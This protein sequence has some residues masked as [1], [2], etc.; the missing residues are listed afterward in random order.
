MTSPLDPEAWRRLERLV[1][2]CL[3]LP[4]N[5]RAGF[6]VDQCSDDPEQLRQAL[7]LV[8]AAAEADVIS[9]PSWQPALHA[10]E[11]T[12][13][14]TVPHVGTT[15]V[16]GTGVDG[17][18]VDGTGVDGTPPQPG[19]ESF[20]SIADFRVLSE[21]GRGGM[22]KVYLA[23]QLKPVRREVA[24]K[25]AGTPLGTEGH[26]RLAAER[27]AMARL[28]HP[29]IAQ[30][31]EAGS[32]DEGLPFFA[33]ER[34]HGLPITQY[35]DEHQLGIDAR[36]RLFLDVCSGVQHAHQKG[37]LH[38]DLK[39][40]NVM[41]TEI[42][43]RPTPKIIDF[44]IAKALD[45]PLLGKRQTLTGGRLLGTPA[46]M[47][48]EALFGDTMAVDTRSDVFSLG[49]LLYELLVGEWPVP[50][51]PGEN[52]LAY[53]SRL[54]ETATQGP[55]SRWRTLDMEIRR[56]RAENRGGD[57]RSLARRLQGDL[58][59]IVLES[60][61]RDPEQRYASVSEMAADIQRFLNNEP[62]LA[63]RPSTAYRLRKLVRRHRPAV[64]SA[65]L[66]LLALTG[67]FIARSLEAQRANREAQEAGAAR[68][69]TALMLQFLLDLFASANPMGQ[70][71]ADGRS[72]SAYDLLRLGTDRL[73]EG[74]LGESPRARTK[75]LL[76]TARV[77]WSL[78]NPREGLRLAEVALEICREQFGTEDPDF[79]TSLFL[80]GTL[81][82]ETDDYPR[83][84]QLLLQALE[85]RESIHGH[86]STE[87]ANVLVNLGAIHEETSRYVEA[88]PFYQRALEI[89]SWVHGTDSL[90]AADIHNNL[91]VLYRRLNQLEASENE[92]NRALEIRRL[93]LRPD[94]PDIALSLRNLADLLR[95]MDRYEEAEVVAREALANLRKN[96]EPNHPRIGHTLNSLGNILKAQ[97]KWQ[98]ADEAFLGVQ[99]IYRAS[100]G[101]DHAW[102]AYPYYNRGHL[103]AGQGRFQASIDAQRRALEIREAH[104]ENGLSIAESRLLLGHALR[105]MGEL[106]QAEPL[107][108]AAHDFLEDY[109]GAEYFYHH[110]LAE[111]GHLYLDFGRMEQ[112]QSMFEQ[113]VDLTRNQGSS[114]EN[115]GHALF[116][117]A[118]LA[119]ARGDSQE[120]RRLADEA[121]S[122]RS[123]LPGDH[124]WIREIH[125]LRAQTGT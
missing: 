49:V 68:D 99:D 12:P 78:G 95:E 114:Q 19:S 2:E 41:V 113:C 45:R 39:P 84:E 37:I 111:L 24:L 25:V 105:G 82:S 42:E 64:I 80:V 101:D 13:T 89:Q 7:D 28:S 81:A 120:A 10:A 93:Q 59:W 38:R 85:A 98:E 72:L 66:L 29:N 21:L 97:G 118:R 125:E 47:S 74:E 61:T 53:L 18:G 77:H 48:P 52:A 56:H 40:S 79:A 60:I 9:T 33:M 73:V 57:T 35:C 119:L 44:G 22:G 32:T 106:E 5:Q 20:P 71:S 34:I 124:W 117:L 102:L 121:L 30:I 94:H 96:L 50:S 26:A 83:S 58:D 63:G 1:D 14:A 67:G 122:I 69:Q 62:V 23:E 92:L 3:Q 17:T 87:V 46:Y 16:D 6:L 55:G 27:Q 65:L 123:I 104:Q 31:L 88:L 8:L 76:E 108:Q 103:F 109:P 70:K 54:T 100:M 107:L 110:S 86:R 75:L 112:A 43:G 90:Q 11:H 4:G 115:F 36:L 116:G 51:T 91:G 15:G